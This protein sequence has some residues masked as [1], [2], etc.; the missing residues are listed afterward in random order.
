VTWSLKHRP[1][2][3]FHLHNHEP[4]WHKS[5]HPV[6]RQL[7]DGDKSTVSRLTNAEVAPKDIRTYIRQNSNIIVTQQD[8]YNRIA[9]SKRELC[10]GQSTIHAFA[11]QLDMEG[12]WNRMRLDSDDR[13]TA[14]LSPVQSH[15]RTFRPTQT[16]FSSTV[17]IRQTNTGC[18]C[19]T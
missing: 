5:A 12:F 2:S 18:H 8:I 11:N 17:H 4:S 3:R 9:D 1:Y 19:L 14:V 13:I 16:C 10:E 6:H 15:R 7:S